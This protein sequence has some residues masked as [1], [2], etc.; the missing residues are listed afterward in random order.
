MR[1][2]TKER[3]K[4]KIENEVNSILEKKT[5]IIKVEPKHKE[6][7]YQGAPMYFRPVTIND[8]DLLNSWC[9]NAIVQQY[10]EDY[11]W[12]DWGDITRIWQSVNK[13]LIAIVVVVEPFNPLGFYCGRS[14][15]YVEWYDWDKEYVGIKMAIC[16]PA[17][18][19][20][21]IG[22]RLFE[23]SVQY[24]EE[25]RGT[26]KISVNVHQDNVA[27]RKIIDGYKLLGLTS[28]TGEI[29]DGYVNIKMSKNE[30]F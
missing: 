18:W 8:L 30:K 1:L 14:I 2:V 19:G 20:H 23:M 28:S 25:S 24:E 22:K 17:L 10:L 7:D 4:L 13:S 29:I 5:E 6:L 15:G 26:G 21:G 9:Q 11:Q 16:D 27:M 12:L 3:P